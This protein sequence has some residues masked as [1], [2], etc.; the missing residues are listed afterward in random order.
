[1]NKVECLVHIDQKICYQSA[2]VPFYHIDRH[3]II[4]GI[5]DTTFVL[6]APVL[7]Y[8]SLSL[9]FHALDISEWKWLEKYRI[10]ES[11]EVKNRNL[12]TRSQVVWAVIIQ[13][14]IQTMLGYLCVG[15][16]PLVTPAIR[17]R[18]IET[19]GVW[20]VKAIQTL[21]GKEMGSRLL[22]LKGPDLVY[23]IYWWGIPITQFVAA[24]CVYIFVLIFMRV[25]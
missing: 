17:G 20:V 13:Q 2:D 11:A 8:W 4:P 6:V 23:F 14:V 5:P 16:R 22:Q 7:A 3:D 15:E 25:D 10:H 21:L 19:I 12:A 18:Q 24:M 1:M 9:V